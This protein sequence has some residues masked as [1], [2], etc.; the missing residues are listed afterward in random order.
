M[1][2]SVWIDPSAVAETKATPG[3]VRQILKRA[4]RDMGSD[5]G[6]REAKSWTGHQSLFSLDA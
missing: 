1:S 2:Y 6:Q 5:R 4:M 3:N